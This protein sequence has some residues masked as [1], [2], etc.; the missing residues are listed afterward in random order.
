MDTAAAYLESVT[1]RFQSFREMGEKAIAQLTDDQLLL[2]PERNS[3]SIAVILSH[4]SGNLISRF[5]DFLGSDGEKPWRDRDAEFEEI[6][7]S[8]NFLMDQWKKGWDLLFSA[9][10]SLEGADLTGKIRIRGESLT[11]VDA[12]TR[13]L[14][15]HASHVGQIIYVAK[16]IRG[17]AWTTLSIPKAPPRHGA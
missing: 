11:V 7:R 14:S 2:Q 8:R 17:D 9:L 16:M 4:I 3:N 10:G 5:T 6:P 15:H 13:Q 1:K 12:L